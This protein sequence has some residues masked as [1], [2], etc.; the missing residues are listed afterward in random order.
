MTLY[1]R[2]DSIPSDPAL[3]EPWA[4]EDYFSNTSYILE[5]EQI[6]KYVFAGLVHFLG[7]VE[8]ARTLVQQY[9][10]ALNSRLEANS[11]D[12]IEIDKITGSDVVAQP[13]KLLYAW[14]GDVDTFSEMNRV[15][16]ILSTF[17]AGLSSSDPSTRIIASAFGLFIAMVLVNDR[18]ASAGGTAAAVFEADRVAN[19]S[20]D[21]LLYFT[22]HIMSSKPDALRFPDEAER[23]MTQADASSIVIGDPLKSSTRNLL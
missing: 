20:Y 15:S 8:R 11:H 5:N 19:S 9:L 17:K 14:D 7:G 12:Q 4:D 2:I 3:F 23:L 18:L 13:H 16:F 21:P 6:P 10:T 22:R 1:A